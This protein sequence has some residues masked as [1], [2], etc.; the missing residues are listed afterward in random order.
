M[1]TYFEMKMQLEDPNP[2]VRIAVAEWMA[3]TENYSASIDLSR[4]IT[5]EQ[6]YQ[7]RKALCAAYRARGDR[8]AAKIAAPYSAIGDSSEALARALHDAATTDPA[9]TAYRDSQARDP[10]ISYLAGRPEAAAFDLLVRLLHDD[11]EWIRDD[12]AR[13]LMRR[14]DE[15]AIPHL[16]ACFTDPARKPEPD[17]DGDVSHA[18]SW[19]ITGFGERAVPYLLPYLE[20]P[21][22]AHRKSILWL[23]IELDEESTVQPLIAAYRNTTDELAR[24][25]IESALRRINTPEARAFVDAVRL[26]NEE[27]RQR[28]IRMIKRLR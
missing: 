28:E 15:A 16:I 1:P 27:T 10:A 21:A 6:D 24:H 9:R 26:T 3:T 11:N 12:A 5:F 19:S 22:E 20:N 7:V 23:M 2:A 25:T 17:S 14:G 13:A 8:N 18:I 4:R